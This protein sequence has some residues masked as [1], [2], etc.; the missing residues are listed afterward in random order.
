[1]SRGL[2]MELVG[3]GYTDNGAENGGVTGSG[4]PLSVI[5]YPEEKEVEVIPY[6]TKTA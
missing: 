1:M 3:V 2:K 6:D 4:S 5:Q